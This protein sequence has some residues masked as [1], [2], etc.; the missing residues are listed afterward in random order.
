[1]NKPLKPK[2]PNPTTPNPITAP[3]AKATSNAFPNEVLAA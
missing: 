2:T 3:P 1:M